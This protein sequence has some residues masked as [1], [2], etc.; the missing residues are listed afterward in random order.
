MLFSERV[1]AVSI[2]IVLP[3]LGL[4]V[5]YLLVQKMKREKI[6]AHPSR[7]LFIVFVVYGGLLEVLLTGLFGMWTALLYLFAGVILFIAPLFMIGMANVWYNKR[8]MS[9]YHNGIYNASRYYL[10]F[11]FLAVLLAFAFNMR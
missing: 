10:I 11:M 8:T 1:V 6:E 5:Y 3:L 4:L 2:Y 7:G 9:K